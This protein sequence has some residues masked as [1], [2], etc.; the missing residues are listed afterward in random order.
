[1]DVRTAV[2]RIID[3][4]P[5]TE[6]EAYEVMGTIMR[7]EATPAQIGAYLT[8]LRMRGETV[9]EVSGSVRAMREHA[10]RVTSRHQRLV[11]TCG[12][13]GDGLHTFNISTT[14]AFVAAG[15]GVPVAKHGNRAASS[16]CGS[17]DVLEA[18][19]VNVKA[20]PERVGQCIDEVGIGFLFAQTHHPSMKHAIGPR[21]ELGVRTI[22]NFLGPLTNPAGAKR[23]VIGVSDPVWGERIA[24]VLARLGSE[25][26]MVVA[27]EDGMDEISNCAPTRVWEL[28]NG[29]VKTWRLCPEELKLATSHLDALKGGDAAEGA[30]TLRSILE[31]ADGPKTDIVLMNAAAA[32]LVGGLAE[33]M[34]GGLEQARESVRSGAARE[35]LA[36]LVERSNAGE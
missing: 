19:G 7:G 18:L 33:D 15:A 9:E 25:H 36:L 29:E 17:A 21:K 8:G 24:G 13:G 5:L 2:G 26:V 31:G 1:M 16:H 20:S 11:D 6:D 14:A 23:Q 28:R 32:I 10:A 27:A 12:T 35:K 30:A 3:G 34:A 22:F 4:H